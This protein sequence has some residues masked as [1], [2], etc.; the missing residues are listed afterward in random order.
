MRDQL[1]E[2]QPAFEIGDRVAEQ[3]FTA[4]TEVGIIQDI[5][6]FE[7]QYRYVVR[8]DDGSSG[9]FFSYELIRPNQPQR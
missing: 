5:Y 1:M 3:Q 8:F 7:G 4:G 9:V 2:D 6:R